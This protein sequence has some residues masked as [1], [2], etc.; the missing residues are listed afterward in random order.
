MPLFNTRSCCAR[1]AD[2]EAVTR[3][4][5]K[6][7]VPHARVT[8]NP[9]AKPLMRFLVNVSRP[10]RRNCRRYGQRRK[11]RWPDQRAICFRNSTDE[12]VTALHVIVA[13][14]GNWNGGEVTVGPPGN[15]TI[16][17]NTVTVHLARRSP[18]NASVLHRRQRGAARLRA[19][20]GPRTIRSSEPPSAKL[21]RALGG[22]YRSSTAFDRSTHGRSDPAGANATE[23]RRRGMEVAEKDRG[24]S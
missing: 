7:E 6:N 13:G 20:G 1:E 16:A 8:G 15:I 21:D 23:C 4:A 14:N 5:Q 24:A 11:H 22:V 9:G 18:R 17:E 2:C 3:T 19:R 12:A 10:R